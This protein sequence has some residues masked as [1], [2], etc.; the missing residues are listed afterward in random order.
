MSKLTGNALAK[1]YAR[2]HPL[3]EAN[4][5]K[6]W[7]TYEGGGWIEL[8]GEG[9]K[10]HPDLAGQYPNGWSMLDRVR[11]GEARR[12]IADNH[13]ALRAKYAEAGLTS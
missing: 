13:K 8:R 5:G 11:S 4:P 1:E 6:V 3:S 7:A 2:T 10:P 9:L 12:R